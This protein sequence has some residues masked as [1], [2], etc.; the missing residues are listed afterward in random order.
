MPPAPS[1]SPT[2]SMLS[3]SSVSR[4]RRHRCAAAVHRHAGGDLWLPVRQAWVAVLPG[5]LPWHKLGSMEYREQEA[6]R[7]RKKI[8]LEAQSIRSCLRIH[9]TPFVTDEAQTLPRLRFLQQQSDAE[10]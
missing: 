6:G 7:G 8:H 9:R 1:V 3:D 10:S 5:V 4:S 2:S